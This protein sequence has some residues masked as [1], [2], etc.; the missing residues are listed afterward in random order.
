MFEGGGGQGGSSGSG[1]NGSAAEGVVQSKPKQVFQELPREPPRPMKVSLSK[2]KARANQKIG[3]D[4][5][6]FQLE[7]KGGI[8][9][10]GEAIIIP[11]VD[12]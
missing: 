12:A 10:A 4:R 9:P 3:I 2:E 6:M 8:R 1:G 5:L 11:V 7:R